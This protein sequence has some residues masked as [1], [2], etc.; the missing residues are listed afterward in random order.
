MRKNK[1]SLTLFLTALLALFRT[2]V[3]A[4]DPAL[5]GA[6]ENEGKLMLY[7]CDV[8]ETPPQIKNFE[9]LYPKIKISSYV[10]GCWQTYNRNANESSS[11][12][13]VAD[14]MQATEDVLSKLDDD[15]ALVDYSPP[16]LKEFP[17]DA[18][19]TGENYILYKQIIAGF[20]YNSDVVKGI[21]TPA[22]WTD[23]GVD[24]P[25]W[26][27]KIS[28]YDPRTSSV[29]FDVLA[30]L[31][32]KFGSDDAG[33]IYAGLRASG[34]ELS[35]TTPAGVAKML[36]G[37]KPIMFYILSNQAGPLIA[38]GT[39]LK[40]TIPASGAVRVGLG[41]G[42][43]KTAV[44]PNAAELFVDY[45]LNEGQQVITERGEYGMRIGIT[46]PAGMPPLASIKILPTDVRA[47][48]K[49]QKALIS[50]WQERT[51]IQ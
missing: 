25:E 49:Q 17:A 5:V 13:P 46:P 29:A 31:Y 21:E 34:A 51:G 22:D 48:L 19:P 1:L 43:L 14:L 50:S 47:A 10:A 9:K 16:V 7:A 44:H 24:H 11:A 38:K 6:A 36:S 45:M 39:P 28:F 12:R 30:T 26:K 42:I 27:D 8:G 35:A 18:K 3:E 40:F 2:N 15:H 20:G 4:A 33:K 23:F 37:E 32:Q 41:L